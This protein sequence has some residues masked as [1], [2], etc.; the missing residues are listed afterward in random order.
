MIDIK[1]FFPENATMDEWLDYHKVWKNYYSEL[2]PDDEPVELDAFIDSTKAKCNRN[3]TK[4]IEITA[5]VDGEIAGTGSLYKFQGDEKVHADIIVLH[6]QRRKGVGSAVL[7]KISEIA[8]LSG[9]ER[10]FLFSADTIP[11]GEL[12]LIKAGAKLGLVQK[13]N[14]LKMNELDTELMKRW[15]QNGYNPDFECGVWIN[16]FPEKYIDELVNALNFINDAP[17]GEM[18]NMALKMTPE[19]LKAHLE[20]YKKAGSEYVVSWVRNIKTGEFAAVSELI[21]RKTRP[22]VASQ[23]ETVTVPKYRGNGFGKLVKAL[24]A[25]FLAEERPQI[26]FI[27]TSNAEVNGAMLAINEKMGFKHYQTH[28]FWEL[29]LK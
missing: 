2:R 1:E 14:Q 19:I 17:H 21:L 5:F 6:K 24:N 4:G 20:S 7:K 22:S 9:F 8:R 13:G 12:F 10:L 29:E 11:S 23:M 25:L 16:E 26:R 27:R 28:S 18:Q 3:Y 15:I